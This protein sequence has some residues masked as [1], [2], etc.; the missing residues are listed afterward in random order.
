MISE[1]VKRNRSLLLQDILFCGA[2]SFSSSPVHFPPNMAV[3]WSFWLFTTLF[4]SL[5][6][7]VFMKIN[8]EYGESMRQFALYQVNK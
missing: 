3:V 5:Y 6:M 4:T 7:Y 2:W 8:E 1:Q